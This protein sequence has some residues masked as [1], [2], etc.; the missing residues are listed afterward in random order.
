M[1]MKTLMSNSDIKVIVAQLDG[2]LQAVRDL[3]D[4]HIQ[5]RY[6]FNADL[7][8]IK[9]RKVVNTIKAYLKQKDISIK[10]ITIKEELNIIQSFIGDNYLLGT[11]NPHSEAEQYIKHLHAWRIQE[12]IEFA[13]NGD[14]K[15]K[16]WMVS[17]QVTSTCLRTTLFIKIKRYLIVLSFFKDQQSEMT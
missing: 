11:S 2:Y 10:Q 3:N 16:R 5:K 15:T 6:W 8:N 14:S 4:D 9:N 1:L 12:Y 13:I 7:L 17:N